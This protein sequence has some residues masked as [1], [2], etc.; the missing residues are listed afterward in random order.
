[1]APPDKPES[2]GKRPDEFALIE[3]LF[4]PL[5][6]D[7]PGAYA[8]KDDATLFSPTPGHETVLTVDAMVEGVHFLPEDPPE[9]IARKLLRVNLS[10]LAAKGAAPKG[11][12][13]AATWRNDT[14]YEWMRRFAAGLES[15]QRS[16]GLSLWGGDTTATEGPIVLSLTAIGE[17]PAGGM[18][19]RG[20]ALPGDAI[21]VTG[22]IGDGALGLL[23]L[24][25][26]LD[27]PEARHAAH[28]TK[29][30]REPEPRISVGPKLC[31]LAHAALDVSDG[32]MADLGHLCEVS[33]TGARIE[34]DLV[35]LSEA[36]RAAVERQPRLVEKIAGGG[37]DYEILFAIPSELA[38]E[39][40]AI[41][42]ETGVPA[43]RIGTVT[44]RSEGVSAIDDSGKPIRLKQLGY[45]HF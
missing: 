17:V 11:Y 34:L 15:D 37:D 23:V 16:F 25:G 6:V 36:A 10:D 9:S 1:M 45:R 31:G 40:E 19:R 24:Q 30:Y 26:A 2:V 29:R 18:I 27:I 7:A 14:S 13:L 21:Y 35:P 22:T 42:R 20:G 38:K 32:L 43:T 33:G 41:A 4:A 28:L 8:L 3:A 39:V 12:L 44:E 5:A